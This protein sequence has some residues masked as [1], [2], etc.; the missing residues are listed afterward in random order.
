MNKTADRIKTEVSPAHTLTI[1]KTYKIENILMSIFIRMEKLFY[2]LTFFSLSF[3]VPFL[4]FCSM[5]NVHAFQIKQLQM[6]VCRLRS[7]IVNI[8]FKGEKY[9]LKNWVILPFC[10]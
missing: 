3:L 9:F 1:L 4:N 2:S 5:E 7:S 6:N 10:C 8:Y